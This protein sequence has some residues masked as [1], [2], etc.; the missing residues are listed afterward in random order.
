MILVRKYTKFSRKEAE[1]ILKMHVG[2]RGL[3]RIRII[4]DANYYPERNMLQVGIWNGVGDYNV[5]GEGVSWR[6]ALEDAGV[7]FDTGD[8]IQLS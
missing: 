3:T 1:K 4:L 2:Q 6:K 5:L 7:Y 8:I